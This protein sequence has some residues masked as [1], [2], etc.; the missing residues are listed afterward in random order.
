MTR[1]LLHK[2]THETGRTQVDPGS[3]ASPPSPS[4]SICARGGGPAQM[5]E[6]N[7]ASRPMY[8]S[9]GPVL[10]FKPSESRLIWIELWPLSCP[11]PV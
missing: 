11:H 2:R 3:L 8:I 6:K 1:C 4:D 10:F 5:D 9:A 7:S